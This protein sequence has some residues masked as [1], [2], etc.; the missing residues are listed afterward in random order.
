MTSPDGL[1]AI[2]SAHLRLYQLYDIGYSIDLEHARQTVLAPSA[3][4]RPVVSRGARI[5][6][7]QL[8]LEI[9]LNDYP[10]TLG[11]R[12]VQ[13]QMRARVY[14]LGIVA[15]SLV[16][17]LPMPLPWPEAIEVVADAQA[18]PA[19]VAAA[20]AESLESLRKRLE[21]AIERPNKNVRS[22]DYT[23]FFVERVGA[24]PPAS[25]L[26]RHPMLLQVALGERK[27]LSEAAASL[28]TSLSYYEDDLIFLTWSAAVIIEPDADARED[29]EL[30]LE[31]ANAQLLSLRSYDGEIERDMARLT[32]RIAHP[33][34]PQWGALRATGSFLHEIYTLI[35]DI[36][37]TSARIQNAL[38][39]TEDVY[40][41]RVYSAALTILRVQ[42]WQAGI[43]ETLGVLRQTA[44]LL[45]DET[46]AAWAT[47][48]E[49][50][51]IVLIVVEIVVAVFSLH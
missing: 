16:V 33:R 21:P 14:D 1:P 35:A 45:H 42:V 23:I 2:K 5:E 38:K 31:F 4:V 36:T 13:G 11:G 15:L 40:W 37:E 24:G 6:I 18:F 9:R 28:A 44:S 19:Q 27:T 29:A 17:A 41:N 12:A 39:V 47:L 20:F 30:L 10:L 8:P 3:R 50:L 22:E 34:R 51:V 32:P 46:Q 25:T 48:L 26:G 43:D 49:I 7:A